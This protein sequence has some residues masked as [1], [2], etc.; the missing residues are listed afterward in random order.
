MGMLGRRVCQTSL[1]PLKHHY[2]REKASAPLRSKQLHWC[3]E[4]SCEE[5]FPSEEDVDGDS[6]LNRCLAFPDGKTLFCDKKLG[7]K[8]RVPPN[9]G[10]VLY[11]INS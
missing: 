6:F 11:P 9:K 4:L 2:C 8:I 1:L 7:C 5:L 3:T 10:E